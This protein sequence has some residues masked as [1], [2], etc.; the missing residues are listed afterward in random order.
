MPFFILL[1]GPTGSG[2]SSILPYIS[3]KLRLPQKYSIQSI[4]TFVEANKTYKSKVNQFIFQKCHSKTLCDNLKKSLTN[5][6]PQNFQ[7]FENAYMDAR[8]KYEPLLDTKLVQSIRNNENI[9]VESTGLSFPYWMISMIPNH[10]EI[11][12][13]YSVVEFCELI[14]R[15]KTRA[16]KQMIKYVRDPESPAPRLPKFEEKDFKTKLEIILKNLASIMK[17]ESPIEK[18]FRLIVVEN[19][20]KL[21]FL[22]D[23][24]KDWQ[25]VDRSV[26]N[27]EKIYNIRKC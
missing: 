23:S 15:N 22:F 3:K 9:I 25:N 16:L 11:Y 21:R 8:K 18:Q 12:F 17:K 10:Y 1:L 24:Y 26:R 5:P 13:V 4:D 19:Q 2:K 20:G 7:Y 14:M 6:S 27:I